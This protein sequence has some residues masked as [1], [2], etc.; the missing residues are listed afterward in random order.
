M[1]QAWIPASKHSFSGS[2][3][4]R[5][6]KKKATRRLREYDALQSARL[7]CSHDRTDCDQSTQKEYFA[8]REMS[9]F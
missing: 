5:F 4:S 2:R 9:I 1:L 6:T 7:A 3:S 8:F